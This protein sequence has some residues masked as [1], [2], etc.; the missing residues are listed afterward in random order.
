MSSIWSIKEKKSNKVVKTKHTKELNDEIKAFRE[1][2]KAFQ[3]SNESDTYCVLVFSCADD[4]NMFMQNVHNKKGIFIDGY[5]I[6]ELMGVAPAKPK[7]KL[8]K[9]LNK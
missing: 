1:K 3:A 4:R 7:Y 6:A 8:P 2:N 9:P 5:K